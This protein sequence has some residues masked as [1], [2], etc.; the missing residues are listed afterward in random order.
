MAA[1]LHGNS[2]HSY[3]LKGKEEILQN[4]ISLEDCLNDWKDIST[5]SYKY[6]HPS[7]WSYDTGYGLMDIYKDY[8][9]FNNNYL[10]N[11]D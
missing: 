6:Q 9:G 11:I 1:E 5:L 3:I 2:K 7:F 4:R 8:A 10:L